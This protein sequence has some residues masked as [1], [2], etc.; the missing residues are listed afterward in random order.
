MKRKMIKVTQ[1]TNEKW[2]NL[3]HVVY[4]NSKDKVCGWIFAS[5]KKDP[6]KDDKIDAVVIVATV[7]T[8]EG[9]KVV[10]T[11]EYRA[12]INDYE[13]G[14]PAGLIDGD[15]SLYTAACRELREETGLE[16]IK[17]LGMSNRIVSSA[18]LSDETTRMLFVEAKGEISNEH[19]EDTEEIET[20]LYDFNDIRSLLV[21]D[22]KVGAKAW[23]VLYHYV[24]IGKID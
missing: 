6:L 2:M 17:T 7:D 21:S 3:F 23:G 22:K 11:R 18:G 20:F 14:F 12:P 9:R 15:E 5:R 19:Q 24:T 8:S 4:R 16:V 13:Y 1:L 10:V